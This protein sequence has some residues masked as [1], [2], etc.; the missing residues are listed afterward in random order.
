MLM[1]YGSYFICMSDDIK[2]DAHSAFIE[3]KSLKLILQQLLY[4]NLVDSCNT[5]VFKM[6][7]NVCYAFFIPAS[8]EITSLVAA[9]VEDLACKC[10]KR[11]SENRRYTVR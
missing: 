5:T 9:H 3:I 1:L 8:V 11:L 2:H 4:L 10:C 7:M 6:N